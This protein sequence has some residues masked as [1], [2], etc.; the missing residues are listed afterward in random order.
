M[1]TWVRRCWDDVV[2]WLANGVNKD[3]PLCLVEPPPVGRREG[4]DGWEGEEG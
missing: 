1:A 2:S 3:S 4:W